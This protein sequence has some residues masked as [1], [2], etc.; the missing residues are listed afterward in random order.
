MIA[1]DSSGNPVQIGRSVL[2]TPGLEGNA[3]SLDPTSGNLRA[4]EDATAALQDALEAHGVQPQETIEIVGA[5][6]TPSGGMGMR[7]TSAGEPAMVLEVPS[8]GTGLGQMVLVQDESGV[9]TWS[10]SEER[11]AEAGVTRGGGTRTYVIRRH[12]PPSASPGE[13][14]GLLGAVGRKLLKVLVFPLIDPIIERGAATLAEQWE[15]QHRPYRWRTFAPGDFRDPAGTPVGNDHWAKLAEGPALVLLHGTFSRAHAAFGGMPPDLVRALDD[16]YQGRVVA[17]DHFTLSHDPVRNVA[18]LI[19]AIPDGTRLD[20]D[21]VSHSRG[22]LVARVLAEQP[23]L[24]ALG[25]REVRV[26]RIVFVAT[27][28]A[29][30]VLADPKRMGELVDR[31]TTLLN[32]FPDNGV[33]D[34]L[35]AVITVVKQLAVGALSGLDGIAAMRPDGAFLTERLNTGGAGATKYFALASNYEPTAPGLLTFARDAAMD[36]VFGKA[37]NDLVVPSLGVHEANGSGCFPIA[38]VERF[39]PGDGVHHSGFFAAP[40]AGERLLEWLRH[41]DGAAPQ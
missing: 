14:R 30:T 29:G 4:E 33:T 9:V 2:S 7:S 13:T 36:R 18:A 12:V 19:A 35:E 23:P 17:F 34:V 10:F 39:G 11:A 37:E 16:R 28:N 25:R 27:P 32:L 38:E 26:G 6:E 3:R 5:F 41:D 8:P 24:D 31:V 22:G 1:L 20:L 21:L 40:R 15:R